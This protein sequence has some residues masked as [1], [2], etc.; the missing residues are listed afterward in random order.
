LS[1][2]HAARSTVATAVAGLDLAMPGPSGPWGSQL[3][4]A[5]REGTVGEDAVDDKVRRILRLARRV[6]ALD[7]PPDGEAPGTAV[8]A[9]PA[10]LRRCAAAAFTLLRNDSVPPHAHPAL[11]LEPGTIRSLA[12]IGPNALRPVTQGG[13]SA[14]VPQV[15]VSTPAGALTRALAGQARVTV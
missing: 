14:T 4:A 12:L 5:V 2:W 15:S 7:G 3:A 1:D 10:L 6:G 8:L 13:G 11:P 9:D